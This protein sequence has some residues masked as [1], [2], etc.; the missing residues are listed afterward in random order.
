MTE[1]A[2]SPTARTPATVVRTVSLRPFMITS[3]ESV[4]RSRCLRA[5]PGQKRRLPGQAG[6]FSRPDRGK[7][8][9]LP[10]M[11]WWK[12]R[13]ISCTTG[14]SA[15]RSA[16]TIQTTKN[17]L[18]GCD[19]PVAAGD[20]RP[21]LGTGGRETADARAVLRAGTCGPPADA[22]PGARGG[23]VGHRADDRA[24]RD[25]VVWLHRGLAAPAARL[26][27]DDRD[28]GADLDGAVDRR[29]GQRPA[30]VGAVP[31]EHRQA[32]G[33]AAGVQDGVVV[34]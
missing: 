31:A 8:T 18:R 7:L 12:P 22:V 26:T 11:S 33:G 27:P 2:N 25:L 30:L 6:K 14:S 24:Y 21:H 9:G 3:H 1:L 15:P 10:A 32:D 17:A 5:V 16:R 19:G 4:V 13:N 28:L 20:P 29:E 34:R 23:R